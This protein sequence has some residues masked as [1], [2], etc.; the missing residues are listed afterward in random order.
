METIVT[1]YST[2]LYPNYEHTIDFESR[3]IQESYFNSK[4]LNTRVKTNTKADAFISTMNVELDVNK[5]SLYDYLSIRDLN[6]KLYYYFILS[7][8][9]ITK[10]VT[11]LSLKLDVFQTYQF[12]M[13]FMQSYVDRC[14]VDRWDSH[15]L[16]TENNLDEQLEYGDTILT[17]EELVKEFPLNFM[18]CA[19][20]PIGKITTGT[21]GSEGGGGGSSNGDPSKGL[22]SC[23]LIRMLKGYE[24]F[25][26]VAYDGG[27]GT[28]TI[29]YGTTSVYDPENFQ[30]LSPECTE[31]D[32]TI[33]MY[34]SIT[35]RYAQQ[36]TTRM[37]SDGVNMENVKINQYDA[38]VD[39]CY[40]A[41]YGGFS[42]SPMYELFLKDPNDPRIYDEWLDWY[43]RDQ[44]GVL[45]GLIARRKSEAE[46]YRNA[47]YEKRPI[48]IIGTGTIVTDNNG[49]GYMPCGEKDERIKVVQSARKLLGVPYVFGG[50]FPPLG[51][52]HGTDCSGLIQWAYND[53]GIKVSRTTYTQIEEGVP[54]EKL[55]D[56]KA[57]DLI[58]PNRDH[59]VMCTQNSGKQIII[60]HAP[61]EGQN[62][63][64]KPIYF[65]N[66]IAIR[67]IIV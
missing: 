5:A 40:N 63:V 49:N 37:L 56:C 61:T 33:V 17:T 50:N 11:E 21:G 20:T 59:V 44:N 8:S 67:R 22:V 15:G 16:P 4:F 3:E 1:L 31:K 10:S 18:I 43:I 53:V 30:E 55:E 39:L 9:Q 46:M 48:N 26:P 38:F 52:D 35:K 28:L 7:Q 13:I 41:G 2:N 6:G 64:E 57:G 34:N 65:D 54:I 29:G 45:P 60:I 23:D 51:N 66:P 19:T 32:A 47:I 24:G 12:D 36:V 58:F 14:H 27:D 62:V 25:S 42:E